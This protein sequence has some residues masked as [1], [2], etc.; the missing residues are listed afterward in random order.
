MGKI[1]I[2]ILGAFSLQIAFTIMQIKSYQKNLSQMMQ[3]GK[4][5]IGRQRGM[6]SSGCVIIIRIDDEFNVIESRC[7]KGVTVFNRFKKYDE[8]NKKNIF[9]FKSWIDEIKNKKIKNAIINAIEIMQEK[10]NENQ[11]EGVP[12]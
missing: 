12:N 8:I 11:G 2:L 3:K 9:E 10:L 1:M 7:M 5:I 6:L 4:I